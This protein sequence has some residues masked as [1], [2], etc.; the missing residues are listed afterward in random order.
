ML[1]KV[2]WMG[3][4][5]LAAAVMVAVWL[6][7][8]GP[9]YAGVISVDGAAVGCVAGSQ[10]DPYAVTYC[11]IQDAI[12]DAVSGDTINVATG[13]YEEQVVIDGKDLT[14]Q[15]ASLSAVIQAPDVLATCFTTSAAQ[16]PVVCIKNA[17][18]TIDTFTVDGAG[19]G[20]A[21][22][23]FSG[24]AFYNAGGALQN[25]A[26]VDIRDTPLSGVQHGVAIYTYNDDGVARTINVSDNT[27]TGFQKNAMALNAS[28]TTPL[29]VD[30]QRNTVTGAGTI[31]VTAQNGI[32]VGAILATGAVSDNDVSGIAY[33]GSGWVATAIL[34]FSD[35]NIV[36]N[37]VSDCHTCIY[38]IDGSGQIAGNTVNA[39]KAGGYSWGIVAS[40]PPDAVPS[41]YGAEDGVAGGAAHGQPL[42]AAATLSVDVSNNEV[43]FSGADNTDSVGIE[44][45]AGYGPNDIAI[46]VNNNAV[47]GFD[48]GI[49]FY[50]CEPSATTCDS[51]VFTA[52]SAQGNGVDGSA[53]AIYS[54]LSYY[55]VDASGNWLGDNDPAGVASL[56]DGDIDYTPWLDSGADTAPGVVGFQGDFSTLWVDDDSLQTGAVGR[57]REGVNLVSGS[58]VKVAPGTY[59]DPL[60]FDKDNLTLAGSDQ[61]N[62]PVLTGGMSSRGSHNVTLRNLIVKGA[63]VNNFVIDAGGANFTMERVTV[64]AENVTGRSGVGGGQI[65][66]D[67]SITYSEF[68]NIK[69]WAA[70]DTRSGSGGP[71]SGADIDSAVFS[72]NTVRNTQG[73]INFRGSI[74]DPAGSVVISDN[75]VEQVGAATNSFGG[76]IKV[77]YAA[78]LAFTDNTVKDVGTSGYNPAGEAAYG[79]GLMPRNVAFLT[80]TGNTFENNHQAIAIEPRNSDATGYADGILPGGT[81]AGNTFTGNT[82]GVYVPATLHPTSDFFGLTVSQN[83]FSTSVVEAAHN[84]YG[85]G[86][87][88]AEENWWGSPCGPGGAGPG[89]GDHVSAGVDFS[90][91][92]TEPNGPGTASYAGG[93]FI[94]PAGA[95]TA[96]AQAIIDCAGGGTV[97]SFGSGSYPGGLVVDNS[98]VTIKLN[99]CTVGAGS[100]AFTINGDDVTIR[101]PG[102]LDGTGDLGSSPG[103]QVNPG[104]DNFTLKDVEV[105]SWVDGVRLAGSG[106]IVSFKLFNNFIHDNAAAG[107]QV[108]IGIALSGVVNIEGNLFKTNGG[109][110]VNNASSTLLPAEY[111]SWGDL[112][113][114]SAGDGVSGN[115]DTDPFTFAEVFLDM[116]PDLEAAERTVVEGATTFDVALKLDAAKL[117]GVTFEFNYDPA[118]LQLNSTTF[119]PEWATRCSSLPSTPGVVA[120]RCNLL[121]SPPPDPEYD[122]D[123]GTLATFSFTALVPASPDPGPWI[124]FFDIASAE[125]ETSAGAVGGVKVFLNNAGFGAPSQ[126]ARDITDADDGKVTIKAKANYTGFVDLQ[127]RPN[128]SGSVVTVYN[129]AL[130][131]GAVALASATSAAGGGYATAHL[132]PNV[133]T[134]DDT[135]WLQI[136]R[137]LYLPTTAMVLEPIPSPPPIPVFW[138]TSKQLT[139]RPL[140]NLTTVVLLGG[141]GTDDNVINIADAS[142]IGGSYLSTSTCTGGPGANSDVNG[143][144]VTNIFDLTLMGGNFYK[145]SSPWTP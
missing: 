52:A 10:S 47:S 41:P 76:I 12:D 95:T 60:V 35:V 19:K 28:D 20:N 1:R 109:P 55:T 48:Y 71:T 49:V 104:A 91:W 59:A 42:A 102:V 25:S 112:G 11:T 9:S 50:Q 27:V 85:A 110:G 43:I 129:Q 118:Y 134:V 80:V 69:N 30:V 94:I 130:K 87:L 92:W 17:T 81:I 62:R 82:Y 121:A 88:Q 132:T 101:G 113:G 138:Q 33:S 72:Y 98:D 83:N 6:A 137:A 141:D 68:L 124:T 64:D 36:D 15:G 39:I 84:G 5:L 63:H 90:P 54:N 75:L 96:Q 107:L 65:N 57:I 77:F 24:V 135:Y 61:A 4:I 111:N 13:T 125:I 145:V 127:G 108:D 144:G 3:L 119:A 115:V 117:Y 66:G 32:Q 93:E 116:D 26:I 46:Q 67:I 73:H 51:G 89:N 74:N 23:R 58:T 140:T 40:D 106:N 8:A 14:L 31:G 53:S 133:L 100:P 105:R 120:Y 16:K 18:A 123:G 131:A 78:S 122:A 143:D 34:D 86:V 97:V 70:F 139:I 21:N 29:V 38:K 126:P 114:P 44:A 22:N 128:E 79:A 45:D 99:S 142:C 7:A 37:A 136:D 56:V 2:M 103:V